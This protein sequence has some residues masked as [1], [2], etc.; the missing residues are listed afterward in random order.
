[1]NLALESTASKLRALKMRGLPADAYLDALVQLAD[2]SEAG[3]SESLNSAERVVALRRR[4]AA[5]KDRIRELEA[6]R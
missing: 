4:I 6:H 3:G 2:G 5:L 1:M